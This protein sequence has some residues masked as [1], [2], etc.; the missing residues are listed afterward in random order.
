MYLGLL[1]AEE[2]NISSLIKDK[3]AELPQTVFPNQNMD[4]LQS[5][6]CTPVW[7]QPPVP[8]PFPTAAKPLMASD[9]METPPVTYRLNI[10]PAQSSP[11]DIKKNRKKKKRT[12]RKTM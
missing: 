1:L 10:L 9:G 8:S 5:L 2:G 11:E 4:L 12:D 7:A 6:N 3:N